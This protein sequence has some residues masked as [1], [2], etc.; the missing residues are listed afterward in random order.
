MIRD[1]FEDDTFNAP[2]H[3]ISLKEIDRR[4]ERIRRRRIALGT[5]ALTTVLVAAGFVVLPTQR[6]ATDITMARVT[7][8]PAGQ[9]VYMLAERSVPMPGLL[10]DMFYLAN[11]G[12]VQ[13]FVQCPGYEAHA[14]VWVDDALVAQG[15]CGPVTEL[16]WDNHTDPVLPTGTDGSINV[17][18]RVFP[19]EEKRTFTEAELRERAEQAEDY[20]MGVMVHLFRYPGLFSPPAGCAEPLVLDRSGAAPETLQPVHC[21]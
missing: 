11:E 9:V 10:D 19:T 4:A 6:P 14:G 2:V 15:S 1:L 12:P 7:E 17:R 5:A 3:R 18:V 13:L 21:E 20:R 8:S 16:R